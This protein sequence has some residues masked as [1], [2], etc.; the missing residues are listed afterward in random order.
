[1]PAP[2]SAVPAAA[3][4][5]PVPIRAR[6]QMQLTALLAAPAFTGERRRLGSA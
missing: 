4:I 6:V 3:G 2:D 1:M 5:R